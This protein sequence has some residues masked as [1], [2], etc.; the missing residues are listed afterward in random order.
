MFHKNIC[1]QCGSVFQKT[2]NWCKD[3]GAK[4]ALNYQGIII[5]VMTLIVILLMYLILQE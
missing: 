2:W 5:A 3:C 1:G 4:R